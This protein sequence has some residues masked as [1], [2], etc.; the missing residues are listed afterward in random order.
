MKTR[1]VVLAGGK[2]KRM[3][4]GKPKVLI[5]LNGKPMMS[6][7]L[8]SIASS[9][10]DGKPVIVVGHG[11]E[12]VRQT[13][14]P[15]YS[16][17][18]QESQLGTGHAVQQTEPVL[19]DATDTIMVLY[20]DHP[21]IRPS[22]I[23]NLDTLH[24][25]EGQMLT[26]MT[27]SVP[28]FNEW[29]VPFYDFGRIVR[30]DKGCITRIVENKDSSPSELEIREVNPALFCFN[31]EW[32]WA[33]LKKIKNDNAQREYYLTDLV[34]IAIDGGE[35][36]ASMNID[37]LEGIGVNTP[38]HLELASELTIARFAQEFFSR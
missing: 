19:K 21:F 5:P 34:Q 14:G 11:A 27:I 38:R 9:G 28:D 33:N 24:R 2:G 31:A 29:R 18:L 12:E 35:T 17:V 23:R 20:G 22:T 4:A 7:L 32:L 15:E 10:I 13:F 26:M 36:I 30:D 16:Y 3:P 37:P 1:V 6:Y 8:K 25:R